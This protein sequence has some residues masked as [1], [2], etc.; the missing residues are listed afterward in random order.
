MG[1]PE[2]G[3]VRRRRLAK[4]NS[5]RQSQ[6]ESQRRCRSRL[7]EEQRNARRLINLQADRSRITRETVNEREV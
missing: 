7:S 2:S 1:R 4:V 3:K 5:A 6:R